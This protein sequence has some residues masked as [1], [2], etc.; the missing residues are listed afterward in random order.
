MTESVPRENERQPAA[1]EWPDCALCGSVETRRLFTARDR[2]TGR[3]ETFPVVACVHC[4]LVFISPRPPV[5]AIAAYYPDAYYPLDAEPSPESLA[6]AEGLCQR[7]MAWAH[8][9]GHAA[10]R[11][12]DVGCGTG[13]FLHLVQRAGGQVRGIEMSPSACAYAG[14]RYGLDVSCG[15]FDDVA[16]PP[17]TVDIMTLWH[18]LEHVHNPLA[19]LR[20]ARDLLAP[21][22]VVLIG[23]PNFASYEAR[24]FGRRWYSLDAPRHLYQFTPATVQALLRQAGFTVEQVVHSSATFGLVYSIMGDLTGISLRLRGRSLSPGT[25]RSI[26]RTLH[27][28]AMPFCSVAARMGRGGALEIVARPQASATGLPGAW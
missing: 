12:L 10:P 17:G 15:T 22:G 21:D 8:A 26:A 18:V 13:V 20:K 27:P 9:H 24:L 4:G 16:L 19:T 14:I 7:V 2:L 28:L 5:Q 6:V 25:W 1:A 3:P 11:V 23:L